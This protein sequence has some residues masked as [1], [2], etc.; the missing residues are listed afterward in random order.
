M[1]NIVKYII[2]IL[3]LSSGLLV[4]GN[5]Y[6]RVPFLI[7]LNRWLSWILVSLLIGYF[8]HIWELSHRPFIVISGTVFLIW[9]LI[10]SGLVWLNIR[11]L[12]YSSFAFFPKFSMNTGQISWPNQ[13]RYIALKNFLRINGFKEVQSIKTSILGVVSLYSPIYKDSTNRILLQL[14]FIPQK[15][16]IVNIYYILISSTKKGDRY[17]T[18]NL[19]LPFGGYVPANW[20]KIRK[21]LC[22]SLKSLLKRHQ[23]SLNS[24]KE[25]FVSWEN[26]PL[27]EIN[28]QQSFLEY[29]NIKE[30]FLHPSN[31]HD[32]YGRLTAEGR[33]RLWKQFLSLKYLGC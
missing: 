32:T 1:M 28:H 22:Y 13:K 23:K 11:V 6:W 18:D 8:V 5:S 24:S 29:Y 30:G 3:I 21:P 2:L 9:F 15:N 14:L 33:Y 19:S 31:L 10:E 17:I 20:V 26:S 12:N 4:Y 16:E 27:D 7:L 25:D